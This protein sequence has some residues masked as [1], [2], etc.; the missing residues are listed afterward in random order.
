MFCVRVDT[1][2]NA[3]NAGALTLVL[4]Y[5][6]LNST[7]ATVEHTLKRHFL[8]CFTH[9]RIVKSLLLWTIQRK[10]RRLVRFGTP[11]IS[12][13]SVVR[14]VLHLLTS[15]ALRMILGTAKAFSHIANRAIARR[16]V[17]RAEVAVNI[18]TPRSKVWSRRVVLAGELRMRRHTPCLPQL[19]FAC[20][21]TQI[22]FGAWTVECC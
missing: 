5:L 17:H 3:L 8:N 22:I 10:W 16:F 15:N 21:G 7:S 9:A 18:L 20:T 6:A 2:N 11:P 1:I 19:T 4:N 12:C 13:A 14:R